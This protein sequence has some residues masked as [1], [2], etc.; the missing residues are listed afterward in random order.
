MLRGD[1]V[2]VT[3][4]KK[5]YLHFAQ[6][7]VVG[8][9]TGDFNTIKLEKGNMNSLYNNMSKYQPQYALDGDKTTYF[10]TQS[11]SNDW[12]SA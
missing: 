3:T 9:K 8:K 2:S 12:W 5:E 1:K 4:T 6:I 11:K 10:H 7:Q